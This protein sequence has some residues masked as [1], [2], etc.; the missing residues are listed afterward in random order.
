MLG[1]TEVESALVQG[2][3][4]DDAGNAF[5]FDFAETPHIVQVGDTTAGDHRHRQRFRE[6]ESGLDIDPGQ[7]AVATDIGMIASTP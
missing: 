3:T 1:G 5:G 2:T 4:G 6:R 7:H